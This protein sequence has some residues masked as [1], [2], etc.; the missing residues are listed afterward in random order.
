MRLIRILKQE[1]AFLVARE[2]LWRAQR[3]W[4]KRRI[5]GRLQRP[6]RA[7]VRNIPYYRP[8]LQ[9]LSDQSRTL[10]I[11][12]AD[13]IRAGRY[14]FLSYGTVELGTRPNWSL[15]FVSGS[16]WPR[17]QF[18]RCEYVR[19]DGSD[20]KVPWELSRL[21][22][23]PV[24]AKA[25]VLTRE[26]AYRD[27]AKNILSDWIAR[28]PVGI[29]VN[30]TV[31][32]EAALRG[33]SICLALNLLCPFSAVEQAWLAG[34]AR[35]LVQH[36]LYIE[37]NIEF[38]HLLTSNHYLS[39]LVGLYCIS[40]FLDGQGMA[41]R[42]H[43]YRQRI[44]REMRRQVYEDGGD[45]EAS[46]GYQ[47]LV[48]QLFTT[49]LFLMRSEPL[50]PCPAFVERLAMMFRFLNTV[51]TPSGELP[52]VGDCDDGRTE[53]LVDDLQQMILYPM[54]ERNSLRVPHLLGL[55]RKLFGEGAGR[56]D[57]AAWYGLPE[58]APYTASD[59][60]PRSTVTLAPNSGIAV[61]RHGAAELFFF[62]IPNGIFGKGSHTHN[63]K[64]S[65]IMRMGGQEVLCDSG[66]GCYTRDKAM[67]NRFRRTAAHNTLLIDR[68]EQN[69]IGASASELFALGNEAAVTPIEC[70]SDSRGWLV[71]ASHSGYRSLGVTHKRTIRVV[72]GEEA[73]VLED[74]VKGEGIHDFEFNLQ[75]APKR[76][77]EL[78]KTEDGILCRI[79]GDRQVQITITGPVSL[80]ASI[81]PSPVSTIYG[82]TTPAVK[83]RVWG[84]GPVPLCITTRI[85]W[86]GVDHLGCKT[87]NTTEAKLSYIIAE[88]ACHT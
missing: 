65:F 77:A 76:T 87:S 45:Y 4:N 33:I 81:E 24:L 19:Q 20:V 37:A 10:I 55:G 40:L 49:A 48:T 9:S 52:Q 59:A 68:T 3:E 29:G 57:D 82:A 28:N 62:A 36:L 47:V 72:E 53:L 35:S 26:E 83:A 69:R 78:L 1:S 2:A 60:K 63:D 30:W 54:A 27:A 38:S 17:V 5:V 46:I 86:A 44:E 34:V 51:A 50:T 58:T 66:T 18:Q 61:L 7:K 15:D 32:M 23:L 73:F 8:E 6:S 79:L 75:L 64:L 21:Q 85:S 56:E 11:A 13:E 41:A 74:E 67:R 42:R 16:E 39:D 12:F 71:R 14:P 43:E 70:A 31:A 88:E 22:F 80:Q 25:W 84:R